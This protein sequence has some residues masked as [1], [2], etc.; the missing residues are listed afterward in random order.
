MINSN[1][2]NINNCFEFHYETNKLVKS[3]KEFKSFDF[4]E[5]T[6]I[7]IEVDIYIQLYEYKKENK[8]EPKIIIFDGRSQDVQNSDK[9]T[10][11]LFY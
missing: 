8:Y 7:P 2:E 6:F 9:D 1:N 4:N 10:L 5:K 11:D 3:K